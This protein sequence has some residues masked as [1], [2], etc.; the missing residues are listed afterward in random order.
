MDTL[1]YALYLINN[2]IGSSQN[3]FKV[4]LILNFTRSHAVT[5]TNM[6][7]IET[8]SGSLKCVKRS[9]LTVNNLLACVYIY[10][11][12]LSSFR[13]PTL[14]LI[15]LTVATC[16]IQYTFLSLCQFFHEKMDKTLKYSKSAIFVLYE[17]GRRR[18]LGAQSINSER[19]SFK[20]AVSATPLFFVYIWER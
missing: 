7:R 13:A 14:W 20:G 4:E 16:H 5:S 17:N 2:R 18:S 1:H 11:C 12:Q 8:I 9:F 19:A 6:T 3:I 10:I 15:D